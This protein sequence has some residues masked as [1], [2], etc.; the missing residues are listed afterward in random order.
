MY[1]LTFMFGMAE[2]YETAAPMWGGCKKEEVMKNIYLLSLR[3]W[4]AGYLSFAILLLSLSYREDMSEKSH[5]DERKLKK[6]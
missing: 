3:K 1:L 4:V 2:K 5:A 6:L